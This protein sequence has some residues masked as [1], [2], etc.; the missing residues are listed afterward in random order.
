MII[1]LIHMTVSCIRVTDVCALRSE[2][3]YSRQSPSNNRSKTGSSYIS[4]Y[5]DRSSMSVSTD[6]RIAWSR[7][8]RRQTNRQTNRETDRLTL[9]VIDSDS[10]RAIPFWI[11]DVAEKDDDLLAAGHERQDRMSTW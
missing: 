3:N 6:S 10:V 8:S 5:V 7:T 4:A 1:S 2:D 9:G 11:F